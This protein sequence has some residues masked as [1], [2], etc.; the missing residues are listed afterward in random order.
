MEENH[1]HLPVLE[2]T[3]TAA[4]LAVLHQVPAPLGPFR[5]YQRCSQGAALFDAGVMPWKPRGH[6]KNPAIAKE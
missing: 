1:P 6:S 4:L 2:G 5:P 3:W